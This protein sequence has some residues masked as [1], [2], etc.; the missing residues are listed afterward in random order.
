MHNG[1]IPK[2]LHF[3]NP[4]PRLDWDRLPVKITTELTEWPQHSDRPPRAGISAYGWSGTNA[5]VVV[6]GY[7]EPGSRTAAGRQSSVPVGPSRAIAVSL[8]DSVA[9]RERPAERCEGR[10]ARLLPISA[11]SE[12]A[13][14]ELAGRYLSWLDEHDDESP[15]DDSDA[16]PGLSEMAWTAGVGRSHFDCRAGVVFRD[17][18]SLRAGLSSVSEAEQRPLVQKPARVAF[19]FTGQGSQWVGM[20]ELLYRS[21]PVFRAVLDRCDRLIVE[22]RGASLLDVMFGRPGAAG[23]LDEPAWT[24][25]AIYALECALTALWESV[26]VRP[27]VVL[28]HSLGEIAA[29]HTAGAFSLE[30]GL[31]FASTRGRL[32]GDLPRAGAMAAVFAAESKVAEAVREWN[33]S[34]EDAD[35]CVAVDNGAQQVISGPVAEVH[36]F[37]EHMEKQGVNVQAIKAQ[38]CIPQLAGRA[39]PGRFG[40]PLLRTSP[41]PLPGYRLSAT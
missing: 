5:H 3:R 26:G 11:K 10:P 37:S 36:A 31:R 18:A 24:Q 28:G 35:L 22:E 20:G 41:L 14:R 6:E 33:E 27:D 23:Q 12:P 16:D 15:V 30:D 34:R 19:T 17:V 21:E 8:P 29:A 1:A 7:G 4:N 38:S 25:P 9:G 2:H 32:M 40:N 13:L 39:G